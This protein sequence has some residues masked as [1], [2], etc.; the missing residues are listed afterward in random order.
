LT[1]INLNNSFPEGRDGTRAPL[2]KQ[3][4]FLSALL[5]ERASAPK[6][7]RYC[8]G[9]GSGKT[10]IGCIAMV[11]MAVLRP[12]DYLVSR[13]FMPELKDT[14]YKT[15]MEVCPPELIAEIR[16]ADMVVKLHTVERGKLSTIMFRGLEEPDKLRSLNLNAFYIDEANQVSEAAFML[17]QGRLRGKHYRKGFLTMN[18][19]GHD[20]SWRWFVQQSHIASQDVRRLFLNI[21]APSMENVH[22]PDGYVDTLMASWSEERIKREIMGSDDSF[23]GQ[24]F[25]EFDRSIH[26]IKP[27]RIP[28]EWTIRIGADDGYRNAAAWVYGAVCPDGDLYIWNEF[29]EKE[30]L[31]DEIVKTGKDGRQSALSKLGSRKVEQMRMDP[32]AKQVKNGLNNWDIYLRALPDGFP[33]L[34]AQKSVATGIERVKAYMKP[35]GRGKPR[36]YIFDTCMNLLDEIAQYK[37]AERPVGQQGKL[38]EKEEPV[39]VNDHACDALRYLVM[40]LPEPTPKN[41]DPVAHLKPGSLERAMYDDLTRL[42][43]GSKGADPF[44]GS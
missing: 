43:Q 15:F 3:A 28:D 8:G 21:R 1:A 25:N 9:I 34:E 17:L 6:Y 22:L 2:P 13:Q 40:T 23:E 38:N 32:A 33:M 16:V 29:Y 31:I 18:P 11:H 37:W 39:K 44:G 19:G 4:L 36:L 7:A 35:D 30:W 12:G 42:K 10:M 14:T 26:V 41:A 20:W 24:I 5:D 27:F